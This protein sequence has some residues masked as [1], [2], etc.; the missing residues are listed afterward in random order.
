M[1]TITLSNVLTAARAINREWVKWTEQDGPMVP[2]NGVM[3]KGMSD[4]LHR[5]VLEAIESTADDLEDGLA[6]ITP[7]ARRLQL[8]LDEI[9]YSFLRWLQGISQGL[10]IARPTG[11]DALDNAFRKLHEALDTKTLPKPPSIEVL[12]AQGAPP[13]Q[14][15]KKYGFKRDDGSPDIE[16]VYAV[17]ADPSLLDMSKWVHPAE[18]AIAAETDR[19]WK[20]RSPRP[21]L[22]VIETPRG[23]TKRRSLEELIAAHAPPAQIARLHGLEEQEVID[24]ARDEYDIDLTALREIKPVTEGGAQQ[25]AMAE[26][27]RRARQVAKAQERNAAKLAEKAAAK[28]ASGTAS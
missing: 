10:S 14:I 6:E 22:F 17:K 13:A 15:A 25:K 1:A 24:L 2:Y 7:D 18:A 12:F 28:Q 11:S 27:E 4:G 19:A 5:T 3:T 9:G 8:I 26:Q 20:H 21:H 16:M 23:Q